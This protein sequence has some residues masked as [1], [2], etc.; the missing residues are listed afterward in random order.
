M[1]LFRVDLPTPAGLRTAL[2]RK[3]QAPENQTPRSLAVNVIQF[4]NGVTRNLEGNRAIS[5]NWLSVDNDAVDSNC[6]FR[7]GRGNAPDESM[8]W[9]FLLHGMFHAVC[10]CWAGYRG[11]SRNA[12]G[13]GKFKRKGLALFIFN[14]RPDVSV[15]F[16]LSGHDAP[17]SVGFHGAMP[18]FCLFGLTHEI[19]QHGSIKEPKMLVCDQARGRLGAQH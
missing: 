16:W 13:L 11:R 18:S 3:L 4:N 15:P 2:R 19:P 14:S 9:I 17:F 10:D 7:T 6:P 8:N 1:G 5:G 12:F